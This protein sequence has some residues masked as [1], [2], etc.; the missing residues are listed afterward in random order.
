MVRNTGFGAPGNGLLAC[1]TDVQYQQ[2]AP[3]LQPVHLHGKDVVGER[4]KAA[5]YVYFPCGAVLSVLAFM[6]NGAAVEVGTIGREGFY[7]IELLIG[8]NQ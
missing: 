1:L 5:E 3:D 4:G 2:L 7:G 6:Q 8:T